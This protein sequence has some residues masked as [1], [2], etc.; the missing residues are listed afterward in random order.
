MALS[1]E[2]ILPSKIVPERGKARWEGRGNGWRRR[3]E[4]NRCI[5]V[6][7]TSALPLGYAASPRTWLTRWREILQG[8]PG[9][10]NPAA[11][12]EEEGRPPQEPARMLE[13]E[14]GVEP[15]TSTLARLHS[16]TE[17]FPL[18]PGSA[19]RAEILPGDSGDCQGVRATP[20]FTRT[21]RRPG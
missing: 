18:T 19:G 6:L 8:V 13:R 14:T 20:R 1:M 21:R 9:G 11:A 17:L 12:R 3:S 10:V 15:A 4:S 5:E 7:Q 16:T 2:P